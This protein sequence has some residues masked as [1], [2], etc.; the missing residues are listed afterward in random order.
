MVSR[1]LS[2]FLVIHLFFFFNGRD[3]T[4]FDFYFLAALGLCYCVGFFLVVANRGDT[5][6]VVCGL[7]TVV[8]SRIAEY[9]L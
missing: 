3:E 6:V 1:V 9:G 8:A 4:A 2:E 7:L 5:L